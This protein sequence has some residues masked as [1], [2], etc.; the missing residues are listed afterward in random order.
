MNENKLIA[1]VDMGGTKTIV[2]ITNQV[3]DILKKETFATITENYQR[4]FNICC[5]LIRKFVSELN[6]SIDELYGVGINVPGMYDD[7][8]EELIRAPFSSWENIKVVNYFQNK[9]GITNIFAENDV[10]SC[11]LGE[12][13]FGHGRIYQSYLWMTVSTGIGG[14][15]VQ[16]GKLVRGINNLAGEIGHTKVEYTNARRCCC[17]QYGCLE[18]YAS[19]TGITRTVRERI[20]TDSEFENE[21]HKYGLNSDAKGCADLAELGNEVAL[22]IYEKAGDYLARGIAS[23]ANLLNPEVIILGGGVANSMDLILPYIKKSI[24]KYIISSLTETKIIKTNLGYE[25]ALLGATALV[26]EKSE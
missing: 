4:T 8:R 18:A 26:L 14:A 10:K 23:A 13:Y 21:L 24:W 12:K 17:G 16:N 19:G 15:I 11:A 1:S 22:E 3:G 20:V 5:E 2:A 9:L 25:A 6:I 7:K